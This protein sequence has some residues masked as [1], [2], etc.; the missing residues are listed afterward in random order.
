M[1]YTQNVIHTHTLTHSHT[2][3][4]ALT[5][6]HTHTHTHTISLSSFCI[7]LRNGYWESMYDIQDKR[8]NPGEALMT[9]FHAFTRIARLV[10]A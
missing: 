1:I 10:S 7:A 5:H 4:H 2:R 6:T 9:Y 8:E 3:T